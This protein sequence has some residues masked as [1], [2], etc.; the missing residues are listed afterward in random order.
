[1]AIP[2]IIGGGM[3]VAGLY[4]AAKGV[5]GAIDHSNAKD[6]NNDAS[7]MVSRAQ[8]SLEEER[9]TTNAKLEDY[10]NRKLRAFNGVI[11]DFIE[12]YGR[13]ENVEL[14]DSPEL[15]KLMQ[16]QDG[17]TAI[18][19]LQHDYQMLQSAG[20]GLGAGFGSGAALAF[21]AYSGT[22]AL[23]TASTGT[24]IA[25]LS[26]VAATNATLAWLGG[27]ALSAGGLGM[28][29]GTMVLGSIVAGPALAI[30]GHIVGNRGEEALHNAKTNLEKAKSVRDEC[31]NAVAKL[32]A[33]GEV[34]ALAN[35][36]L[37]TASARVRG[38]V[39]KLKLVIEQ[40]GT[41]FQQL[42]ED[43][44]AVVFR[45]VKCAQLIKA[46]IDTAILDKDG[47]LV[48]ATKK[49]VQEIQKAVNGEAQGTA[50]VID[51]AA[52]RAQAM[53]LMP[54][55]SN[56]ASYKTPSTELAKVIGASP[57]AHLEV[58]ARV[59]AYIVKHRLQDSVN[60]GR[61]NADANLLPVFGGKKQ[62]TMNE[63]AG[64]LT[65]HLS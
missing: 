37:M 33:I 64:L 20:L 59:V 24:A 31:A 15:D 1:M 30:F 41:D 40:E 65:K 2:L 23:A 46:M 38:S 16:G 51:E 26:G 19:E 49:R 27:G 10:G 3:L 4:G 32:E 21:G 17:L 29:G 12:T 28:A 52:A 11:A 62:V 53:S 13:L 58:V 61:I 7:Y 60:E 5:S 18:Q 47:N 25:S 63:M 36:T 8:S 6:M 54:P 55:N 39:K 43:S 35:H 57:M 42:T 45:T 44:Q 56:W 14:S 22:M 9:E 48:L 50:E 34:V